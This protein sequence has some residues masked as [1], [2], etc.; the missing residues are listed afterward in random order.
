[1]GREEPHG[2]DAKEGMSPDD[3]SDEAKRRIRAEEEYRLKLR[4]WLEAEQP[5]SLP[6]TQPVVEV[7]PAAEQPK[8]QAT[9]WVFLG[10]LVLII[11]WLMNLN[12]APAG[13]PIA[14]APTPSASTAPY[15]PPP[16]KPGD[17][18]TIKSQTWSKGGFGTVAN[19]NLQIVN[20]NA[21]AVKDLRLKCRFSGP[22]GTELSQ[23][24]HTIYEKIPANGTKWLTEV[25]VGFINSQADRG[26]CQIAGADRD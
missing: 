18:V 3:L 10:I 1:M 23:L 6:T 7:S 20:G 13:D 15:Q 11:F 2:A 12:S 5:P 8:S 17:H 9:A 19:V 4:N 26:Y 16:A 14:G 21:Y 24:D 25:N 22:S